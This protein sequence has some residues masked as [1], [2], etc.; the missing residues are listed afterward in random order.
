VVG[1][2]GPADGGSLTSLPV[3]FYEHWKIQHITA[4]GAIAAREDTAGTL[5][6]GSA[7]GAPWSRKGRGAGP[8]DGVFVATGD[9]IWKCV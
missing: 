2:D 3:S 7:R 5:H 1:N 6:H 8:V 4:I 9:T